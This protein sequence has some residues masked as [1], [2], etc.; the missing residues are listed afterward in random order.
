MT[1]IF[2]YG[3]LVWR[4]CFSYE[5]RTPAR[6]EG[7]S[8]RFW[9]ASPDHRGTPKSPGRVAT[10]IPAASDAVWG[11]AYQISGHEHERIFAQLD[12]REAAGYTLQS[13]ELVLPDDHRITAQTYIGHPD[14]QWYVGDEGTVA[15]AETIARSHGPSGANREYLHCL[16]RALEDM[17]VHDEHVIALEAQ[18]AQ[19]DRGCA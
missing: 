2:G 3:S 7:Y 8:R 18:I 16:A 11:A 17:G 14:A 6:L 4:P 12:V 13:V 9:Q 5:A 1:W 10:L 19:I 15:I